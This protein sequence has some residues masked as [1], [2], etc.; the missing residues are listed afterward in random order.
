VEEESQ[1]DEET[2]SM[3]N[4]HKIKISFLYAEYNIT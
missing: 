3:K 2:P 1:N 4:Y